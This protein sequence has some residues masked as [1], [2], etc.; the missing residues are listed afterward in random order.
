LL[1][2]R[3]PNLMSA[4]VVQKANTIPK[5]I[6]KCRTT[7]A[8]DV[9]QVACSVY[10]IFVDVATSIDDVGVSEIRSSGGCMP[11]VVMI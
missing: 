9:G 6:I 1:E 11:H 10:T 7:P 2:A 8:K 3:N 5:C 4:T